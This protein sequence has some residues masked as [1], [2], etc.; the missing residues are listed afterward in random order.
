VI[1]YCC[2][3]T[4]AA[5][6]TFLGTRWQ[7]LYTCMAVTFVVC[8]AAFIT[9]PL[10]V[11][12]TATFLY[13]NCVCNVSLPGVIAT[14]YVAKPACLPNGP[15]FSFTFYNVIS[16]VAGNACGTLGVALL[17]R[18]CQ[19]CSYRAIMGSSASIIPLIS[20][21]DLIIVKRRSTYIGIPDNAMY[22]LGDGVIYETV[23]LLLFVRTVLLLSRVAPRRAE[24]AVLTLLSSIIR[25]GSSTSS[26]IG[27]L[28]LQAI[29]PVVTFGK[30]DYH[31]APWLI[32]A[33]HIVAPLLIIPL[34]FVLLPSA[35]ASAQH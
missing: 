8:G 27:Y 20:V 33:C 15:H 35:H 6:A 26:T 10:V 32:V 22:I 5:T 24:S 19:N 28:L 13:F 9:L 25:F 12:K 29:W 14:F 11:A 16:G 34:A 4:A 21:F 31:N 18:C 2:V 1:V 17:A 7:L 30:C 3:M 23:D